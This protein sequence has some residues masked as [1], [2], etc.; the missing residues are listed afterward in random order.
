MQGL[1]IVLSWFHGQYRPGTFIMIDTES[2]AAKAAQLA[3]VR[4]LFRL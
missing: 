3:C 4:R 1:R 2:F